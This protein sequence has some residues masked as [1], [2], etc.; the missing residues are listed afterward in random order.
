MVIRRNTYARPGSNG[1]CEARICGREAG[2]RR[3][4]M[5]RA[6]ESRPKKLVGVIP[7]PKIKRETRIHIPALSTGSL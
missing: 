4:N 3:R 1:L 5:G 7:C 2:T 6:S